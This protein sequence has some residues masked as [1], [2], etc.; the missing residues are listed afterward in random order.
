MWTIKAQSV[1]SLHSCQGFCVKLTVLRPQWVSTS[2][3]KRLYLRSRT[4]WD[5]EGRDLGLGGKREGRAAAG[6]ESQRYSEE[7]CV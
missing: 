2:V 7:N 5:F 6:G 4:Q 1:T 3:N